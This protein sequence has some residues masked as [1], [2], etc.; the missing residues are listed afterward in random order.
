MND[1]SLYKKIMPRQKFKKEFLKTPKGT[2]DIL[3]HDFLYWRF[4]EDKTHELAQAYG[5]K[6]IRTPHIEKAELFS[7]TLGESSDVI[8]KQM[9]AFKTRG[10]D[11]LVLRPEGTVPIMRSYFEHGMHTWPQP[12]M[13]YYLGSFFRHENPQRGRYREFGQFGAEIIG[14]EGGIA[15]T[16]IIR[17][18]T[19]IFQELG[20]K[21]YLVHINT[22]GD[23]ECRGEYRKE[24]VSYY[25]KKI[26][27]LCKDCKRRLKVNPLRLLDC[28]N[29]TCMEV[30]EEAPQVI[31]YVCSNCR[32]HFKSILEFLDELEIPYYLDPYLVRGLDYYSRTVFEI[33]IDRD[34]SLRQKDSG[35]REEEK[36]PKGETPTLQSEP[37]S[38]G[39]G[40][41]PEE[42]T[43]ALAAG[44]R[45]DYLAE[46]L[47]RKKVPAVGGAIGLDRIIEK[48]KTRKTKPFKEKLPSIFLIQLGPQAKRKSLLLFEQFR[49][50]KFNITQSFSK[51]SLRTQLE[52]A[53]KMGVVWV[54]II[55]QKEALDG[56]VIVRDMTSGAQESVSQDKIIAYL[57][58][59]VKK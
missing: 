41:K 11:P 36:A 19:L 20:F 56:R 52:I 32:V 9:Y 25:R 39:V 14:E 30:R 23:K 55:G 34:G 29:P 58:E 21:S 54:L 18:F 50:A 6:P 51:D 22:L 45:Y 38:E 4:V 7:A 24:L 53:D 16:L 13:L 27:S 48:L 33:F 1:A 31:N 26:N 40:K 47:N 15:D 28:K 17:L 49:K 43:L 42:P 10:G 59:K 57:R 5:Y 35:S 2:H 44:G 3:P 46:K 37:R 8:E 12:V